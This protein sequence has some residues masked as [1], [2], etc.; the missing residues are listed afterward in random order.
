MKSL[1]LYISAAADV[2]FHPKQRAVR[3]LQWRK[4]VWTPTTTTPLFT[5][6]WFRTNWR[7]CVWSWP[8]GTKRSFWVTSFWEEF[9]SA[10]GEVEKKNTYEW[11]SQKWLFFFHVK[12][13]KGLFCWDKFLILHYPIGAVKIGKEE[14]EMN[15]VGEEVS[16]WEKMM[17]Y[18]DSWAEGT[19][20]LRS[21]MKMDQ[22]R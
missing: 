9:D 7:T 5:L 19:L 2:C 12:I 4:R 18:P 22:S 11:S 10:L 20:P 3:R 17:Q 6:T 14:V 8:S 16:L 21:S 15:S 13:F 1:T